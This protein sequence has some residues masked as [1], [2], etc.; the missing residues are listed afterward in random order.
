MSSKCQIEI[1]ISIDFAIL[2]KL[3]FFVLKTHLVDHRHF[4]IAFAIFFKLWFWFENQ[5]KFFHWKSIDFCQHH[6]PKEN[7]YKMFY[8]I[9]STFWSCDF[10]LKTNTNF[11][12]ENQ[13]ILVRIIFLLKININFIF[14]LR[15]ILNCYLKAL[16]CLEN[17]IQIFRLEISLFFI[18]PF[19]YWKSIRFSSWKSKRF[20]S[21]KS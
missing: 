10:V 2:L 8:S 17:Q 6:F 21:L 5:G 14:N 13:L 1:I 3:S 9:Y 20:S 12:T 18:T 4:S 11:S 16:F 19:F 15:Y 7:K